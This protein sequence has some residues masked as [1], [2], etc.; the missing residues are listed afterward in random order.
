M[1]KCVLIEC[2][3]LNFQPTF[4]LIPV[5]FG[6]G[7]LEGRGGTHPWPTHWPSQWSHVTTNVCEPERISYSPWGGAGCLPL[8]RI[9]LKV[10]SESKLKD[11]RPWGSWVMWADSEGSRHE[12][13]RNAWQDQTDILGH[14]SASQGYSDPPGSRSK[15]EM[16]ESCCSE[17]ME[18]A[19]VVKGTRIGG[20]QSWLQVLAPHP[21]SSAYLLLVG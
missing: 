10:T 3:C 14:L 7:I 11:Y 9:S 16:E 2:L 6:P 18:A 4:T 5:S 13:E 15:I 21:G 20:R 17:Q 1:K 8:S 12:S 19:C